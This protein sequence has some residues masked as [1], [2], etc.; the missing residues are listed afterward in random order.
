MNTKINLNSSFR[1][2]FPN[3]IYLPLVAAVLLLSACGSCPKP[4][5]QL[6]DGTYTATIAAEDMI[7]IGLP[8]D[9]I[10]EQTGT[11]ALTVTGENW[12]FF[13]TAAPGCVVKYPSWGGIW[14]LCGDEATFTDEFQSS[15]TYQWA[16]D[17]T[18]LRF[19]RVDDFSPNRIVYMTTYPWVLQK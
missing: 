15:Y 5:Q 18:E 11:F 4:E 2:T 7:N 12:S 17:G 3:V 13:Q 19:T 8:S 9:Q 1:S 16:F 10:C 6:P 14:K